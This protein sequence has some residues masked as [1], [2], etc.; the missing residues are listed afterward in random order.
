V[1]DLNPGGHKHKDIRD[2]QALVTRWNRAHAC[3]NKE[4]KRSSHDIT[5]GLFVAGKLG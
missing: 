3:A 2:F 5:N 4:Q 1:W